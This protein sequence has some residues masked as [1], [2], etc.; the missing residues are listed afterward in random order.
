MEDEHRSEP[1]RERRII[2]FERSDKIEDPDAGST[3]VLAS[4]REEMNGLGE[5]ARIGECILN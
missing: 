5:Q 4:L 1:N 3:R 2:G